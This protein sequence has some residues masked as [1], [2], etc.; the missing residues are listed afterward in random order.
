MEGV[1]Q[2]ARHSALPGNAFDMDHLLVIIG[3][4]NKVMEKGSSIHQEK[5]SIS[6]LNN[7]TSG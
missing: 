2:F 7:S 4:T 6:E 1:V 3:Q 5:V